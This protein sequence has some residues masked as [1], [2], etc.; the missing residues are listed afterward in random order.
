[1]TLEYWSDIG[2]F[3]GEDSYER[4]LFDRPMS[5]YTSIY[6]EFFLGDD[7]GLIAERRGID[8]GMIDDIFKTQAFHEVIDKF[9]EDNEGKSSFQIQLDA[10]SETALRKLNDVLN[11]EDTAAK[12]IIAAANA[13]AVNFAGLTVGKKAQSALGNGEAT[14]S[15]TIQAQHF[16]VGG[17]VPGLSGEMSDEIARHQPRDSNANNGVGNSRTKSPDVIDV[18]PFW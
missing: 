17:N 12:D 10:V 14:N 2:V 3:L 18:D 13:V 8:G 7:I 5:V 16:N 6:R 4:L 1:M 11:D 15:V 9:H